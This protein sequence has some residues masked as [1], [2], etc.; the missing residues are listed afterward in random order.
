MTPARLQTDVSV[1]S[2]GW[3]ALPDLERRLADVVDAAAGMA[4]VCLRP[5]AEVS[6]L[7]TDDATVRSLNAS[8]RGQDKP[9]NVLSFPAVRPSELPTAPMLGDIALARETVEREAADEGKS[10]DDHLVH[11][12]VHGFLHLLGYDHLDDAEAERMES[13]ERAILASLGVAD[14]YAD[15]A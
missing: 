1:E 10:V 15:K 2:E 3:S 12:V 14:P 9:T 7:L 4:E 6:I 11:L 13:R 5:G 8:W